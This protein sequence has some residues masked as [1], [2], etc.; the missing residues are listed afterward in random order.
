MKKWLTLAALSFSTLGFSAL[1]TAT[2]QQELSDRL[3]LNDGFSATFTQKVT[4]PEGEVVMEGEGNVEISR[5]SM[6]RWVTTMPDENVLVSDGNNLW[7]YSPFIEQVSIYNQEQATEQTPFVL[8]TRNRASDWDNYNVNQKGDVFTLIPT[9]VDSTQGQ[10]QI[11]IDSKGIVH[12]FNVIEQDGQ[13]GTFAF[14]NIKVG[15]PSAD[16]F[17]FVIPNGVEVDDQRN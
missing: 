10:F 12:G 14:D 17:T 6:F 7:Y 11:N 13:K 9:A 2:P 4:S 15:K 16:R 3:Q 1:A 5:P 8:L